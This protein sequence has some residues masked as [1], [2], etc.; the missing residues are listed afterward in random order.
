MFD[1]FSFK[2]LEREENN[3][4]KSRF[5]LKLKPTYVF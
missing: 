1:N 2:K 4:N 5:N 3:K